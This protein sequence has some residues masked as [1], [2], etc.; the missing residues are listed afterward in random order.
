MKIMTL[1][2]VLSVAILPAAASADVSFVRGDAAIASFEHVS[3]DGCVHT[4]GELVLAQ[5][6]RGGELA[7]GLYI[8]GSQE[9]VCL[10]TG[11]GFASFTEGQFPMLGLFYSRFTGT[12]IAPSYSSGDDITFDIDLTWLGRGAISHERSGWHDEAGAS[13]TFSASR[14]ARTRGHVRAN[15]VTM[16]VTSARLVHQTSGSV[17]H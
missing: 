6:T 4:V 5:A 1:I 12:V 2:C 8:T 9:D 15:G 11:N 14:E 16:E 17:T 3:D 13:F 10:G 7:D